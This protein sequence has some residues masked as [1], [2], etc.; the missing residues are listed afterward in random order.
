V[1]AQVDLDEPDYV[2]VVVDDEDD[3]R[4]VTLTRKTHPAD[5]TVLCGLRTLP[6]LRQFTTEARI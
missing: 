1:Q 4:A 6:D 5:P 2:T 3:L